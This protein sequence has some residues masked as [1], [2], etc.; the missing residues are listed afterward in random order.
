MDAIVRDGINMIQNDFVKNVIE[1]LNTGVFNQ[2]N[3]KKT[4]EAY[5]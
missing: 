2:P 1:Y 4:I 5:S 3:T